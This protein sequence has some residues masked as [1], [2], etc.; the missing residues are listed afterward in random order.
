MFVCGLQQKNMVLQTKYCVSVVLGL[1]TRNIIERFDSKG[2][3][4]VNL[5]LTI[6]QGAGKLPGRIKDTLNRSSPGR[7]AISPQSEDT[8]KKKELTMKTLA[9]KCLVL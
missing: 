9:T 3:F 1:P 2:G 5:A 4:L 6:L 7:G 8:C